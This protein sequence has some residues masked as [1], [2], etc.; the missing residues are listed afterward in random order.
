MP[1]PDGPNTVWPPAHRKAA[2]REIAEADAWYSGDP[3]KLAAIY[4]STTDAPSQRRFIWSRRADKTPKARHVVH[5]PAAA[6][7]AA[8]SADL[9][10]GDSP[11]FVIPE[12]HNDTASPE[13]K[14]AEDRLQELVEAEA[15][16]TTLLEA[17]DVASGLGGVYLRP[18]WDREI[19]DHPL[20]DVVH[21]DFAIPE[22]AGRH[23]RAVT[24]WR[25]VLKDGQAVWRHLERH[26]PGVVLHG[27]YVG[28]ATNLGTRVP[29]D[30]LPATAG[31]D[32]DKDG[33]VHVPEAVQ[34]LMV[35]YVPNAPNRKRRSSREGAAD[36]AGAESLMDALDETW[37]SWMRDIRLGKM[38]IIV[39]QAVLNRSGRG[40]GATFD[41]DQEIFSPVDMGP[42]SMEKGAHPITVAQF[43][44]RTKE[45]AE[46]SGALFEA[47]TRHGGYSPQTFGLQGDGSDQT[48]TEVDARENRSLRTTNRKRRYWTVAEDVL[49]TILVLDRE[50]FGSGV[51]PFRPRL[52]WPEPG[53]DDLN[54]RADTIAKIEMARAAS[55]E[56]KVR[57]MNPDWEADQVLA[58]VERI[59]AEQGMVVPDPTGGL[60]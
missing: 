1:L 28:T 58:E 8:T 16:D 45:H 20:L 32:A 37:S 56:T 60:P 18:G 6:D 3:S 54:E 51:E 11:Q 31:I 9:L 47:I 15:I 10:F 26:E 27:L 21:P 59:H 38:R 17:A 40:S 55:T 24:F 19:A 33:V 44:I 42:V 2:T 30:R 22:F 43:T 50:I 35:R 25:D 14:A 46:T 57:M 48:A 41:E 7:I 13:A 52:Q 23:L 12:A 5:L 39:D 36:T 34:G 29:L 4:S 49:H 53:G